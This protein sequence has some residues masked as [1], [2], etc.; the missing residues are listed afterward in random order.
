MTHGSLTGTEADDL[1]TGLPLV[2]RL[3]DGEELHH[4][5]LL[6]AERVVADGQRL[7]VD[8]IIYF[9]AASLS[10]SVTLPP[11]WLLQLPFHARA[12]CSLF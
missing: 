2:L 8:Y 12:S 6:D 10:H 4:L 3:G 7:L 11:R 9:K 1:T 5:V